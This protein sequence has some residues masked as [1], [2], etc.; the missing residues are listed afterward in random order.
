MIQVG[1]EKRDPNSFVGSVVELHERLS[2]HIGA[3]VSIEL[4]PGKEDRLGRVEAFPDKR[5]VTVGRLERVKLTEG[6]LNRLTFGYCFEGDSAIRE[7]FLFGSSRVKVLLDGQWKL[8]HEPEEW[9][10]ESQEQELKR[11]EITP[12]SQWTMDERSRHG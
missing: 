6:R 3:V 4:D 2:Y 7:D 1:T 11:L 8:I 10:K 9:W 12:K 5:T